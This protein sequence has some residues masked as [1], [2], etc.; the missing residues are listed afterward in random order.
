MRFIHDQVVRAGHAVDYFCAEDVP[1]RWQ[2]RISRFAFPL[3]V[4]RRAVAAARAGKP[5][6]IINVHEPGAAAI[7]KFRRAA[8]N[9]IVVAMSY[10]VERRGW[11]VRLEEARLGRE[12]L[13]LKTRIVYP[14]TSLWQSKIG[15]LNAD[16]IFCKNSEDRDYLVNWLGLSPSKITRIS[17]GAD[18]MY[19]RLAAGRNYERMEKLLFAG[20][21]IKRKGTPDLVAAFTCLASHYPR[22]Q[23][24]VLGGGT[25]EKSVLTD[26][27]PEIRTR[28]SC[29]NTATEEETA[30]A[31]ADADLFLL[32]S[33]FEGT[34]L[35][36]LE[37]MMSGLPIVTANTCGM[38]D[39]I[40][41]G[42]NGLL[43]PIRSPDAIVSAVEQLVGDTAY[44]SRL[45]RATQAEAL[46]KYTWERVAAPVK[47]IYERLWREHSGT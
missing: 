10:G 23:L 4:R 22:L 30:R 41:N 33:L 7:A 27:P 36:L 5:Y 12:A 44:R 8:G 39:V 40:R 19:A 29:V 18:P 15:F 2:G 28:V 34:P 35:T 37:A 24:I 26:F 3:L 43:V 14:L 38:K 25:L 46:Q 47:D 11:G 16:H 17:P 32:P 21:W 6:D 31:F 20:T 9:P 45:G 1:A 13:S 42:E